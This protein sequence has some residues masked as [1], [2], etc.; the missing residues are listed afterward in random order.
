MVHTAT[1][2]AAVP[3]EESDADLVTY[4]LYRDDELSPAVSL[5]LDLASELA[6]DTPLF[7]DAST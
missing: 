6:E 7:P 2:V 3:I 5:V 4:L 1:S